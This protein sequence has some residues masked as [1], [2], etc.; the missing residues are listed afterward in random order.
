MPDG[1]D[2]SYLDADKEYS[3][4]GLGSVR[5]LVSTDEGAAFLVSSPNAVL[6]HAGDLNWWN[7][8]GEDEAWLNEQERVFKREIAK[9]ADA[10]IDA[11]FIVLDDRLEENYDSGMKYFLS[12]CRAK[13]VL[14]MHFTRGESSV[15][16]FMKD[17]PD[18]SAIILDTSR[19]T[20]FDIN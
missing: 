12:V 6:F 18:A 19:K 4:E 8:P 15:Q 11:A 3:V 1:L 7:W 5:T 14:P 10:P 16:R 20:H 9:I 17:T 2:I 13:C